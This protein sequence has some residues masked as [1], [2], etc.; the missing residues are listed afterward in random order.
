MCV[1]FAR[2]GGDLNAKGGNFLFKSQVKITLN[3]I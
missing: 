2:V 1:G 3:K